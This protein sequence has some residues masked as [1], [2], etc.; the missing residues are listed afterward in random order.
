MDRTRNRFGPL[1][2]AIV[3]LIALAVAGGD[4]FAQS[5]TGA[6]RGVISGEKDP[7]G[8]ARILAVNKTTGFQYATA[9]KPDG[10]YFLGGLP[11]GQYALSV[12]F[13]SFET[14]TRTIDILLGQTYT[15]DARM[16]PTS[17][18]TEEVTTVGTRVLET[19][20]YEIKT[21]I[22]ERQIELLPQ[23]NRN[24]LD[25]A[26]LAPGVGVTSGA[27]PDR[28]GGAYVTSGAQSPQQ[29]NVYI[30]GLSYKN[31]IIKGGAFMQ[32]ASKGNPFPQAA[33]QEMQ[34]LTQNFKAEYEK[35]S[36]AIITAVT[37][38]GG[39]QFSGD[40]F[41][42]YQDKGMV[43]Q[44]DFSE[45][46][47]EDKPD[48]DRYQ[49]GLSLGG[50]IIKDKLTF[51]VTFEQNV[52]DRFSSV[53]LGP[54]ATGSNFDTLPANIQDF[55]DSYRDD[56]GSVEQPFDEKLGFAKI[57]W[58][59][60]AS[61]TVDFTGMFRDEG[62]E[63]GFGGQRVKEGAE[64]FV[65]KS[66]DLAG[67]WSAVG[68]S[69]INNAT[70]SW[71]TQE[72]NPTWLN[73][74]LVHQNYFGILD[75][76]GKDSEQDLK[77]SRI[78]LR[79]DFSYSLSGAGQ[80]V[81]KAGVYYAMNTYDMAKRNQGNPTFNYR[82]DEQWQFPFEAFYGSGDPGLDIDNDQFGIYLQDDWVILPSLTVNLGLRW[83][84][85]TNMLNNDYVTPGKL[86]DALRSAETNGIALTDVLDLDRYTT[87]GSS[88][89]EPFTN[90]FQ[91]RLGFSWD[92]TGKG[93]TIVFGGWG[94][95]YDRVIINDIFDESFR[96]T[97]KQRRFCFT[98]DGQPRG[99]CPADQ[100]LQ[101]DDSYLSK[102][103][104]DDLIASGRAPN[105]EVFLVDNETEPPY[106]DQWT[107][108]IRQALDTWLFS[109]SYNNV[110]GNNGLSWFFGDLYPDAVNRWDDYVRVPGYGRV[111]TSSDNRETWYDAF[112]FTVERPF[113]GD[114]YPWGMTLAWTHANAEQL[115][116][117]NYYYGT[118]FGAFDFLT[119]DDYTRVP[120]DGD[121]RDRIVA[122]GIV[123]F[124]WNM[125]VSGILTLG[126]GLPFT[127]YDASAGWDKFR[128]RW[129]E[130]RPEQYSFLFWDNWAY[131]S[132]DLRL[133]QDFAFGRSMVWGL[134]VEGFNIFDW[135]NY[136]CF[137]NFKPPEGNP[138]F[139]EP[140]CE[141]NQRQFQIG[142]RFSF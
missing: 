95:Y 48:Y 3:I 88:D 115:G 58:Q 138:R 123:G 60:A 133:Q 121:E 127:V 77:Q 69:W 25:F 4:A 114:K 6:L 59:P 23:N 120:A 46:R 37:K 63:R 41:L 140:N 93:K 14:Q 51:F 124:P 101:W 52:Q 74:D 8:G 92:V 80:H 1:V 28:A 18:F 142:T 55:V 24:F 107:I 36:A 135:D 106:S 110:K 30:D 82:S 89:R 12:E 119:P 49:W 99:D 35:A 94:R 32:D 45:E 104:L 96:L 98:A 136:G 76:G 54:N 68:S 10:S 90:A 61:H 5:A 43:S 130:G 21:N 67:R 122:S 81:L 29:T 128:I 87:N 113:S 64:D 39:N 15:I 75:V 126:S 91:P 11:P 111:F 19:R 105:A 22:T 31:D 42:Q 97:W 84:Y 102:S 44:D 56:L 132:F 38:T 116:P 134:Y 83:D 85:E 16:T 27:E 129:N 65:I 66:Y 53:F 112:Y 86:K 73:P 100:V 40:V 117:S 79:D 103:A 2:G 109:L 50:P 137:E 141:Y 139:G 13:P 7:I 72:W 33:V 118:V 62:E 34:V 108:G 70:L 26:K 125:K 71:Q 9:T 47:G 78:V 17:L 20:E 131:R 57:A